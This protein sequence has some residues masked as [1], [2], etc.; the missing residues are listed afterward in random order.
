[1][2]SDVVDVFHQSTIVNEYRIEELE[3]EIEKQVSSRLL[4]ETKLEEASREPGT[5]KL[6][7]SI[8][9]SVKRLVIISCI[10]LS[11]NSEYFDFRSEGNYCRIQSI[12]FFFSR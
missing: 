6:I 4:I 1:M 8:K 5:K 7:Y 2:E 3:K 12:G 11:F 9:S 10:M